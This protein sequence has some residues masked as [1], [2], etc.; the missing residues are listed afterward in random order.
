[1][2]VRLLIRS[3]ETVLGDAGSDSEAFLTTQLETR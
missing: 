2:Q 1:M 3:E